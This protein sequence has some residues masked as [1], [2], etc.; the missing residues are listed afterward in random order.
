MKIK[1]SLA[2]FKDYG[3]KRVMLIGI[4]GMLAGVVNGFLGTGGGIILMLALSMIPKS[5]GDTSRDRFAT[6][7][8]VI[9]PL[10][11]ISAIS[12]GESASL[13]LAA[14]YLLPGILGGIVGA[15]LLDKLSVP[16]IKRLFAIMVIWAGISFL[17]G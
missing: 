17:R 2:F 3:A 8:A 1:K 6:V 5:D 16:L 9:L 10:S 11:L 13:P 15:I 12:Y 14:P 4:L 7:I